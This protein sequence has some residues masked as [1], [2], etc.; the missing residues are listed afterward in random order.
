MSED[1]SAQG[2]PDD[3]PPAAL[4]EDSSLVTVAVSVPAEDVGAFYEM[5]GAWYATSAED[6]GPTR[7]FSR[8]GV[9]RPFSRR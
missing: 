1:L 9:S 7:P 3:A 8:R 5:V 6:G 2:A 4:E